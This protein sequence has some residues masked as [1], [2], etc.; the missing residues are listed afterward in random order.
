MSDENMRDFIILT[1]AY[2]KLGL[3]DKQVTVLEE[4]A[5]PQKTSADLIAELREIVFK[6]RSHTE[7]DDGEEALG[8]EKGMQLAADMIENVVKRHE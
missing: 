5:V 1:E 2:A 3:P 4:I 6:L 7:N 8:V